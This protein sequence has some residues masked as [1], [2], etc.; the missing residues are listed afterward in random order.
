MNETRDV[1]A[2]VNRIEEL[3]AAV[4]EADPAIA[5]SAEELVRNLMALYGAA[6]GRIL[7]IVGSH[8]AESLAEDKL[9]GSLLLLHGLHPK[10]VELRVAEALARIERRL[11]ARLSITGFSEDRVRVRV[12]WNGGGVPAA[13][14]AAMIERAVSAEAPEIAAVEIEG[15]PEPMISLVQIAPATTR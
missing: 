12:E 1:D 13:A 14:A 4:G 8:A 2:T 7:E 3:I 5:H 15:L 10:P 9:V 6:F 11:D